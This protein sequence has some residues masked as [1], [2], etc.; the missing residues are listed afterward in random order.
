MLSTH[1][2]LHY[3]LVWA[4]KER[5]NLID[6]SWKTRLRAWL[7]GCARERVGVALEINGMSEHVH[8]LVGLK[9][10]HRLADFMRVLKSESSQWIHKELRAHL[11]QWQEGY[12]AVSVGPSQLEK[13]RHHIRNPEEHHR[14]KTFEEEY[15]ELLKLAGIEYDERCL[16]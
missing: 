15:V 1:I 2:N 8:A 5:R 11:F 6:P 3:H 4:T 16:W 14:Q 9:P 10:T 12:F 13:V 7:G